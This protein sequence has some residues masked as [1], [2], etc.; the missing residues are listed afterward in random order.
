MGNRRLKSH[1]QEWPEKDYLKSGGIK[2]NAHKS[3]H[4]LFISEYHF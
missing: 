2:L 4:V 1:L 3:E